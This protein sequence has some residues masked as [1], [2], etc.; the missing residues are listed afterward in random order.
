MVKKVVF[1]IVVLGRFASKFWPNFQP[2]WTLGLFF[3]SFGSNRVQ[4]GSRSDP[5]GGG[6]EVP[7]ITFFPPARRNPQVLKKFPGP[8]HFL[9]HR[10]QSLRKVSGC[11]SEI[12]PRAWFESPTAFYGDLCHHPD[13]SSP[14]LSVVNPP[15]QKVAQVPLGR[16]LVFFFAFWSRMPK[17]GPHFFCKS[18]FG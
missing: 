14:P 18:D 3:C 4:P 15:P 7:A 9:L 1:F 12:N 8:N 13:V 5:P 16:G 6:G 2:S 10:V 17:S 11:C